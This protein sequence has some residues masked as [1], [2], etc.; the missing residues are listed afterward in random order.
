MDARL[1]LGLLA[2]RE[3]AEKL[4]EHFSETDDER[5]MRLLDCLLDVQFGIIKIFN[6][7]LRSALNDTARVQHLI[8][9]RKGKV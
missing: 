8:N 1:E 4:A 9:Q 6:D 3:V 5:G 2:Q 7:G